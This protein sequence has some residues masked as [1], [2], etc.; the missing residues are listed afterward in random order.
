MINI[1]QL[2]LGAF[3]LMSDALNKKQQDDKGN[4]LEQNERTEEFIFEQYRY[5]VQE[6]SGLGRKYTNNDTFIE[7]C[8]DELTPFYAECCEIV[9]QAHDPNGLENDRFMNNGRALLFEPLTDWQFNKWVIFE[10]ATKTIFDDDGYLT[11]DGRLNMLPVAFGEWCDL[12]PDY[13]SKFELITHDLSALVTLPVFMRLN[14]L[15]NSV[16]TMHSFIYPS[17]AGKQN[18]THLSKHAAAFGWQEVL[19][20]LAEKRVFGDYMQLKQ[21][22]M[23]QVLEYLNCSVSLDKAKF[24]D[25]KAKERKKKFNKT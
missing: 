1:E 24:K 13:E 20:G 10:T 12:M 17:E 7:L 5:I 4:D 18:E 23:L 2:S 8:I 9:R 6:L 25:M 3:F 22:P 19:R 16:K 21:T 14:E 15:I 11:Q